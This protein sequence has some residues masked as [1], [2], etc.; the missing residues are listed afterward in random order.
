[1]ARATRQQ[2]HELLQTHGAELTK[3]IG[4]PGAQLSLPVKP[5]KGRA[6]VQVSVRPGQAA[7]VPAPATP[8]TPAAPLD[9]SLA[10]A[11]DAHDYRLQRK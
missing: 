10:P 4:V 8:P 1:M 7:Q 2:I 3:L 11:E 9:G 5:K 6:Y